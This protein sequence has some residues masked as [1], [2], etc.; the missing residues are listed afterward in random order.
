MKKSLSNYFEGYK[1]IEIVY[2]V[3]KA[4]A[5]ILQGT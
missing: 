2:I 3:N 1:A 4:I 5:G